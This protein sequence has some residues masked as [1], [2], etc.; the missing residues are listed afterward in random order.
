MPT[1]Y[2][3]LGYPGSGK[4]T[5]ALELAKLTGAEMIWEDK[6]RKEMFGRPTFTHDE[7]LTLHTSLNDRTASLLKSG[8]S[9]IYDTSFNGY[10]DRERMYAIAELTGAK[11]ILLW[12]V[13]DRETAKQRAT[14]DAASQPTRPLAQVIGDMDDETFNRLCNKL[15]E[16]HPHEKYMKLDG[17]KITSGYIKRE[18]SI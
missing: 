8:K 10:A 18:L 17:T 9:V 12:V 1:L 4:T 11:T 15:E 3:L 5:T 14:K 13:T 16:P 2:M 7:N 6:E